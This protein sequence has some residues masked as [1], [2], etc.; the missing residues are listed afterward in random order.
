MISLLFF[1]EIHNL[2]YTYVHN[3]FFVWNIFHV[4]MSKHK[5]CTQLLSGAQR[6]DEIK[7]IDWNHNIIIIIIYNILGEFLWLFY[8]PN[9]SYQI[10]YLFVCV[11]LNSMLIFMI[12]FSSA[13]I[14]CMEL[15]S[16]LMC[17]KKKLNVRNSFRMKKNKIVPLWNS[18]SWCYYEWQQFGERARSKF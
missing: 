5:H 13:I 2:Q 14:K 6:I 16:L 3:N 17:C 1:C 10:D 18:Y 11:T 12:D 8:V 9:T 4:F 7:S 15:S